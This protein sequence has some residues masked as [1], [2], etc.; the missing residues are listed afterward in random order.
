LLLGRCQVLLQFFADSLYSTVKSLKELLSH[1]FKFFAG[2][3]WRKQLKS[4]FLK[5][6][7]EVLRL[8]HHNL[9]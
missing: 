8:V 9:F 6:A 2:L 7:S 5:H 3:S 4:E 1:F